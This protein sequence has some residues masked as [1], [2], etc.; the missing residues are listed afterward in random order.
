MIDVIQRTHLTHFKGR[1]GEVQS[2]VLDKSKFPT[3]E[4]AMAWAKDHGFDISTSRE[5]ANQWRIR[6][7]PPEEC[8]GH[9]IT[10]D[11]TEGVQGV[12]CIQ[13]GHFHSRDFQARKPG[14]QKQRFPP[15]GWEKA[16]NRQQRKLVREYDEWAAQLKREINAKAARGGTQAELAAILSKNLPDL[17]ER[18]IKTVNK[19]TIG[20][21]R[22]AAGSRYDRPA[23]QAAVE[24]QKAENTKLVKENL[25]PNLHAKLI[26]PLVMGAVFAPMS[27]NE[28]IH[29]W[30]IMPAQYAG[31]Y[32]VAIFKTQKALGK[33]RETERAA[34][35][36]RPEPVRWILDPNAEH[37]KT[38]EGFSGCPDLAGEYPNGWDSL[39]TVPAGQVTCRGN[40]R[41]HI[42]VFRDGQWQRGVYED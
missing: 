1:I 34:Q 9:Y 7:Y 28:S 41:C 25:I 15:G 40:C 26:L 38:S 8:K 4:A 19:G 10:K 17:E 39:P 11:L 16:T 2:V 36:L 24:E 42:E 29:N 21:A 14:G 31:G 13:D 3:R 6:Q 22:I 35:G 12:V 37:C 18:M 23:V 20:A 30:R 32:W 5:T 27:L 33:E